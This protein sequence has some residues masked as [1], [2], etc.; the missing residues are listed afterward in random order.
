MANE[1]S[2]SVVGGDVTGVV[3]LVGYD[4]FVQLETTTVSAEK[5]TMITPR[6]VFSPHLI[7]CACTAMHTNTYRGLSTT[8]NKLTSGTHL[9]IQLT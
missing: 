1:L 7:C 2:R 3:A 4:M 6:K 8:P 9:R 5:H